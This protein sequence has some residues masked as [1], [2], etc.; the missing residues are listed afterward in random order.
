[1]RIVPL[2]PKNYPTSNYKSTRLN[3]NEN[4]HNLAFKNSPIA[5]KKMIA[6]GAFVALA[7]V[8]KFINKICSDINLYWNYHYEVRNGLQL[9]QKHDE[10]EVYQIKKEIVDNI[11]KENYIHENDFELNYFLRIPRSLESVKDIK[12]T[13]DLIY[14]NQDLKSSYDLRKHI[15]RI[16]FNKNNKEDSQQYKR[17]IL[18][19]FVNCE[20]LTQNKVSDLYF[21]TGA[22]VDFVKDKETYELVEKILSNEK[23]YGNRTIIENLARNGFQTYFPS[24]YKHLP[25]KMEVLDEYCGIENSRKLP[26][27]FHIGDLVSNTNQE[28][29]EFVLKVLKNPVLYENSAITHGIIKPLHDK[30]NLSYLERFL[31]L[32]EEGKI[33]ENVYTHSLLESINNEA[34][35]SALDLILQDEKCSKNPLIQKEL[36]DIIANIK[37]DDDK[38][39]VIDLLKN[40]DILNDEEI[41][42]NIYYLLEAVHKDSDVEY[43]AKYFIYNLKI[44]PTIKMLFNFIKKLGFNN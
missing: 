4:N 10:K 27:Y 14:S 31:A 15:G 12:A 34:Q 43:L 32:H 30:V 35:I 16:L 29:K 6:G 17:A 28:N 1:M 41:I 36:H 19:N 38:K 40:D 39:L 5:N 13:A 23:L 18:E 11:L 26:L 8:G 22:I 21:N 24:N 7:V 3:S 33:P 9:S 37:T 44:T 42:N 2:S 25:A 20:D